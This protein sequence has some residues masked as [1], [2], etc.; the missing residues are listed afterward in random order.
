MKAW[1]S[2]VW[3]YISASYWFVPLVMAVGA[4]LLSYGA[5]SLDRWMILD[6]G[7]NLKGF[8][9]ISQ[10][11]GARALLE[12][13]AGSIIT[14]T[15]VV[16]SLTIIAVAFAAAQIGPRVLNNF[17]HDKANQY[18]LGIF[19]ATFI[20]CLLVLR[21]IVSTHEI[22]GNTFVPQIAI[23]ICMI[24]V[25]LSLGFLIFFVHHIPVSINVNKVL[26]KIYK[27]FHLQLDCF[28]LNVDTI[29]KNVETYPQMDAYKLAEPILSNKFGYIREVDYQGLIKL[30]IKNACILELKLRPGIFVTS[31]SVLA[32][33][34][35]ELDSQ[36]KKQITNCFV[37]G[38]EKDKDDDILFFPDQVIEI[39]SRAL[40][41]GINTPFVAMTAL[42]WLQG[43]IESLAKKNIPQNYFLFDKNS[44]LRILVPNITISEFVV[45][46]F[47]T[48]R[49]YVTRDAN[50]LLYILKK[51]KIM[52]QHFKNSELYNTLKQ[53]SDNLI[54]AARSTLNIGLDKER[55]L[56]IKKE[57]DDL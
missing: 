35:K 52:S 21:T 3:S 37:I 6:F 30:A 27:N 26:A 39:I 23:L 13:V 28:S 22:F 14:V 16:F 56:K 19:I 48:L 53:E 17:M 42:D 20:Y 47:T 51:I 43:M 33:S 29:Q 34:N 44:N 49:P 4:I 57:I 45:Y 36:S 10:P 15:G 5:I 12:T 1:L 41:S 38:D 11:E 24:L 50:T 7:L 25:G 2:N 54:V 31:H 40:S 46:I 55:V 32:H 9:F 18:T 8:F